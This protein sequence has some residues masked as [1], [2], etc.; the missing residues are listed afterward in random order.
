MNKHLRGSDWGGIIG[1]VVVLPIDHQFQ[2]L[3]FTD[4]ASGLHWII[5]LDR[6][7]HGRSRAWDRIPRIE[8]VVERDGRLVL[9]WM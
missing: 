4:L 7:A 1:C 9:L 6:L 3:D 5:L 2:S 8:R